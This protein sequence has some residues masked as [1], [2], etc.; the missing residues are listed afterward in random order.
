[1]ITGIRLEV[2]STLIAANTSHPLFFGKFQSNNT[3][4]GRERRCNSSADAGNP[5]RQSIADDMRSRS[6][7]DPSMLPDEVH[8]PG[9]F[10][11]LE[12]DDEA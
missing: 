2:S 7:G 10:L 5:K 11:R 12:Y 8:I 6:R 9:C 1:M 3:S 4:D